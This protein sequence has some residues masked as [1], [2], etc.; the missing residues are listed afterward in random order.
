MTKTKPRFTYHVIP[1][2]TALVCAYVLIYGLTGQGVFSHS[3]YDSYTLQAYAWR[4]GRLSLPETIPPYSVF[5]KGV[6]SADISHLEI[7]LYNG[8]RFISFPPFPSVVMLLLY[9]IFGLNTPDNLVNTLFGIGTFILVYRYLMKREYGGFYAALFALLMTLGSNLL[10]ISATGWVW[11]TAQTQSFFF[12]VLSVYLM[13]SE[14]KAAWALSFLSLGFAVGCRPF[15]LVYA[16]LL[17][18]E[19]YQKQEKTGLF[20][21]LLKC[22]PYTLPLIITGL[23][24]GVY[25]YLRFDHFFEFGHNYL[26]EF[27]A[28]PQFSLSYVPGNIMEILKLPGSQYE[29]FWPQ[30]NGTLFF[31]INPVFIL[32][33]VCMIRKMNVRRWIWF[34][35]FIVHFLALLCH[36][37]MG[38][39][40]FGCRSVLDLMPFML[41]VFGEERVYR[42]NRITGYTVLPAALLVIG[43]A[44]NLWGSIWFYTP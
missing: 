19:L 12:S 37:T 9:P 41:L 35:C 34:A 43:A 8:Q 42:T 22:V 28:D 18:Y 10:F 1:A 29:G 17:L 14:K 31:L 21:T 40:H 3:Q 32:A 25:N 44:I 33:A 38:G 7:A 5:P 15:Q 30:F 36:K 2:L 11:F 24:F 23:Y 16:P 27:A 20:R 4:M 26:P 13:Q 39:W 6:S